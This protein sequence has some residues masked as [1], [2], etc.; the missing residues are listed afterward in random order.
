MHSP[1]TFAF[2]DK[3][4]SISSHP[5]LLWEMSTWQIIQRPKSVPFTPCLGQKGSAYKP[6][7]VLRRGALVIG[8]GASSRKFS[9]REVCTTRG[10]TLKESALPASCGYPRTRPSQA[11]ARSLYGQ[12]PKPS[13]RLTGQ[14]HTT[15]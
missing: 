11:D 1:T 2:N 13:V 14:P 8:P 15:H 10:W 7:P 4:P 12:F 5:G 9:F 3:S 6:S